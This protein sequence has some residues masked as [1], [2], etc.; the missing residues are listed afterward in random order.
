MSTKQEI[1]KDTLLHFRGVLQKTSS[2][3]RAQKFCFHDNSSVSATCCACLYVQHW[4]TLNHSVPDEILESNYF[5]Q[6]WPVCQ[7]MLNRKGNLKVCSDRKRWT[8]QD[9]IQSQFKDAIRHNVASGDA[10][11][12][13]H[14]LRITGCGV[15]HLHCL[16][17]LFKLKKFNFW[18]TTHDA[19][20]Q[21]A[22]IV[23]IFTTS[24]T[25]DGTNVAGIYWTDI[26]SGTAVK[27]TVA[28]CE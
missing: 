5:T 20:L 21:Q 4:G 28:V 15:H 18:V 23:E 2:S 27:I 8:P 22:I 11:V 16:H 17:R 26:E 9:Y 6:N 7:K 24:M 14:A 12:V 10:N 3:N 1:Q 19:V 25:S 13:I